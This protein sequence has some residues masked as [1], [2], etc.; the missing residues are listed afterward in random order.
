M[1]EPELGRVC[2]L[3]AEVIEGRAKGQRDFQTGTTDED[4]L[5]AVEE[6]ADEINSALKEL[7]GYA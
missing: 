5:A 7:R 4:L 6:A 2:E 1:N 3:V